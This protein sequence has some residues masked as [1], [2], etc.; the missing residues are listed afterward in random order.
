M[1]GKEYSGKNLDWIDVDIAVGGT[2]FLDKSGATIENPVPESDVNI[3]I[4][5]KIFFLACL[6][7]DGGKWKIVKLTLEI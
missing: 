6:K 7:L 4:P 5:S 2:D 3:L 1:I